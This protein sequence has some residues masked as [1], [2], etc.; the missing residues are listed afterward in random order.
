MGNHAASLHCKIHV[1]KRLN[2]LFFKRH[3]TQYKTINQILPVELGPVCANLS[4]LAP[5]QTPHLCKA[6][7]HAGPGAR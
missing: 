1:I 3:T 2:P 4:A 5:M 6:L 7:S